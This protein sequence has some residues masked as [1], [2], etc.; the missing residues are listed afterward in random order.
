MDPKKVLAG[1]RECGL[2]L[3]NDGATT[4]QNVF[5]RPR[6]VYDVGFDALTPAVVYAG[7]DEGVFRST[8][9]GLSWVSVSEGLPH[10]EWVTALG[11][12]PT[13]PGTLY[14]GVS[15]SGVWRSRDAGVSWSKVLAA[16]W[17]WDIVMDPLNSGTVFAGTDPGECSEG[18]VWKSTDDGEH[19]TK[20]A[21]GDCPLGL[22][23]EPSAPA[24]LYAGTLRSG[25]YKTTNAGLAW[26]RA[27]RGLPESSAVQGIFAD[28]TAPRKVYAA[29]F[30]TSLPFVATG[31][32]RSV[33]AGTNWAPM[34]P[35]L[36]P[37][38]A[39]VRAITM[40]PTTGALLAATEGAGVYKLEEP[41]CVRDARTACFLGGR[42]E[43]RVTWSTATGNG[44]GQVMSFSGS[45]A[46]S[47]QSA[48][49]WFFS[50]EN[51]EMGVKMVD[52]CVPTLGNKFWVFVSGLTNQGWTL[53][54]RDTHTGA[55]KSYQNATGHLSSTIA[56]TAAF[57]CE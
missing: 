13:L 27:T 37:G 40:E 31:F 29:T 3:S 5:S 22:A 26:N 33:D 1:S 38:S 44:S 32:F 23:I 36:T 18:S 19:W 16:S 41:P 50:P 2:Y 47:D 54:L 45:R 39:Y 46:E 11:I 34:T 10:Q 4:W 14:A 8:D 53:T 7:T 20:G 55:I 12:S 43:A 51:F 52:A 35:A 24:R 57:P 6:N 28:P 48:F 49:F 42:F 17:V 15:N 21:L 56:D 30:S 9:S 25:I